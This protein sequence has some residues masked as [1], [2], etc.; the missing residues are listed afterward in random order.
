MGSNCSVCL[1]AAMSIGTIHR[2]HSVANFKNFY[3]L[4]TEQDK[5]ACM[6]ATEPTV[7]HV[8]IRQKEP[9]S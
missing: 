6:P 8:Q 9:T 7:T 5:M 2:G 3:V 1:T 4:S